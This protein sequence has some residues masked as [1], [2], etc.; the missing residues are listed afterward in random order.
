MDQIISNADAVPPPPMVGGEIPLIDVAAY[1]AGEP[2]A[3]ERAAAQL[4]FA[5]ENVGFYYLAGHGVPQAMI[6]ATYEAARKRLGE[7]VDLAE[8]RLKG[9]G[10]RCFVTGGNDDDPEVLT[11][12]ADSLKGTGYSF[13]G[14][15]SGQE[16]LALA[17]QIRPHAITLDIM[18]PH[19]DGWS[20][21]QILKNDP[22][23]RAI[24]VFI[25]SIME[26]KALGFS[27]GVTDSSSNVI[28]VGLTAT[29]TFALAPIGS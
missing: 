26:N 11:L 2:G 27:L 17:R 21:L 4:R 22:A 14:A 9:T 8:T 20:V 6:D 29:A 12:L 18:M 5:F 13:L 7:W 23:L 24:P 16:G 28:C 10:I 1:L 3:A 25:V 15:Q 19:M